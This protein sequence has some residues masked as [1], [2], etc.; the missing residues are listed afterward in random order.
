AEERVGCGSQMVL[1]RELLGDTRAIANYDRKRPSRAPSVAGHVRYFDPGI[2]EAVISGETRCVQLTAGWLIIDK[3]ALA[4]RAGVHHVFA[5]YVSA[6][7][8]L[9]LRTHVAAEK[10]LIRLPTALSPVQII[11]NGR[12]CDL[13][14][15]IV[16]SGVDVL[17]NILGPTSF[18]WVEVELIMR[19]RRAQLLPFDDRSVSAIVPF[20]AIEGPLRDLLRMGIEPAR[21]TGFGASRGLP[22]TGYDFSK[23]LTSELL[24]GATIPPTS[25]EI[26]RDDLVRRV[27]EYMWATVEEPPRLGEICAAMNCRARTL[28]N[29]FEATFGLSPMKYF[30]VLR[31]NAVSRQIMQTPQRRIFDAAADSGFWHMGHF[32]ADYKAMFG[33]TP[34]GRFRSVGATQAS[35]S[36]VTAKVTKGV[37]GRNDRSRVSGR[38]GVT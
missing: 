38:Q 5:N 28:I 33:E 15:A 16:A 18:L 20:T 3:T 13:N 9:Q 7:C 12:P 10:L 30:K 27:E 34:K 29:A 14:S 37:L 8:G 6:N 35:D 24:N 21:S 31:L 1:N 19:N 26:R 2:L 4:T 25:T 17:V 23:D 22:E 11:F 32:G 36:E